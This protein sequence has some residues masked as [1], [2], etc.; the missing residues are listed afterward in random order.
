VSHSGRGGSGLGSYSVGRQIERKPGALV[1]YQG[2][3]AIVRFHNGDTFA[4]PSAPLQK[5]AIQPGGYF[6]M[7][8]VRSGKQVV[9]VSVEPPPPPRLQLR[10]TAPTKVMVKT[11]RKVVTRK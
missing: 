3:R 7:V 10:P 4:L 5:A 1:A 6:V 2:N 9:Q 8:V 11:G